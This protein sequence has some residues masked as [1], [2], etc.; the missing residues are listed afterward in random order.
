MKKRVLLFVMVVAMIVSAFTFALSTSAACTVST[1]GKNIAK[2][3][4]VM[5][6][7][8]AAYIYTQKLVDG[9]GMT[10]TPAIP[11]SA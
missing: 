7:S 2:N 6:S 8:D 11:A 3:A 4:T 5:A 1:A 10:A 9:N